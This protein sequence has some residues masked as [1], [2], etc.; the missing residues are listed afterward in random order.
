MVGS[1]M[2][3]RRIFNL[4]GT[5]VL[6]LFLQCKEKSN[7]V[8]FNNRK[9]STEK[10]VH[11]SKTYTTCE[12]LIVDLVKSSDAK[13]FKNYENIQIE[14]E[15]ISPESIIIQLSISTDISE[16]SSI[17]RITNQTV[18]WLK[19]YPITNKLFDITNDIENPILL[20]YNTGNFEKYD[21]LKLCRFKND[22][23]D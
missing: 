10:I 9:V 20:N 14:I 8:K 19:F 16:D 13:F 11:N 17:K 5:T 2:K 3:G 4:F 21:V 23:G 7:Q 6:L 22:E 12:E 1:D 15:S 18:G